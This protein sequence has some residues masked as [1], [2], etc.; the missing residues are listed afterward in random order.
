MVNVT[1]VVSVSERLVGVSTLTVGE[2]EDMVTAAAVSFRK[3][4]PSVFA[5]TFA[6]LVT[7]RS[8]EVPMVPDRLDIVSVPVVERLVEAA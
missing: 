4:L 2:L 8:K 6:A 1:L 5:V 3:T 7:M